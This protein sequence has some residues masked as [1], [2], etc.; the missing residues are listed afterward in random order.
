VT[1][2]V[3]ALVGMVHTIQE[4]DDAIETHGGWTIQ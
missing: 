2:K 3:A 4:I 1:D